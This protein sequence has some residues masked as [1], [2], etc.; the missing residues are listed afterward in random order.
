MRTFDDGAA[1]TTSPPLAP[2][3]PPMITTAQGLTLYTRDAIPVARAVL[4]AGAKVLKQ[5]PGGAKATE[6]MLERACY[7]LTRVRIG[8]KGPAPSRPVG[9][10]YTI[11]SEAQDEDPA[12]EFFPASR[13]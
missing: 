10:G 1:Y 5:I 2:V 7:H 4:L 13:I 3:I 6:Y 8:K 9:R 11:E 12:P